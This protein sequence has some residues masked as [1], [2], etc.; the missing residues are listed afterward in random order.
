MTLEVFFTWRENKGFV[1]TKQAGKLA[2]NAEIQVG[3]A[4]AWCNI[5]EFRTPTLTAIFFI[6]GGEEDCSSSVF[7]SQFGAPIQIL[8]GPWNFS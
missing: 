8:E 2:E 4:S 1:G 3:G 6:G 7:L 5:R